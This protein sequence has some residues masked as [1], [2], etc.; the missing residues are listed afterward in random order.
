MSEKSMRTHLDRHGVSPIMNHHNERA[1]HSL[2]VSFLQREDI[3]CKTRRGKKE[4]QSV[5]HQL[6]MMES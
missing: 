1:L 3:G 2:Q 6:C 4:I 5:L